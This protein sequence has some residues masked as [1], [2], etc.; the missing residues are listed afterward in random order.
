MN[1][2]INK[3]EYQYSNDVRCNE[4]ERNSFIKLAKSVFGLDFEPWYNSGYWTTDYIPHIL[5]D[6]EVVVANVSVNIINILHEGQAKRYVQLGTIMT[7]SE[8]RNCG[9][10]RWLMEKVIGEWQDKCDCMYLYANDSV[11]DFYPKFEFEK[12]TEYQYRKTVIKANLDIR[13]LNMSVEEDGQLLLE[14]YQL[15]NPYSNLSMEGNVGLLM[16]YCLQ[17]MRDSIYYLPQEEAIIIADIEENKILCYDIF[18]RETVALDTLIGALVSDSSADV[19]LGFSPNN[20]DGWQVDERL[21]GNS[22]FYVLSGKENIF[23]KNK[24]MFPLLSH[25]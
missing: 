17:F 12:A 16:F 23:E 20:T 2:K 15:S 8:Y 19:V 22:T 24:L 6:G 4:K 1:I 9:L 7:A 14:K 10:S 11:V 25:A 3:K 13:K 21:E 18:A 5:L